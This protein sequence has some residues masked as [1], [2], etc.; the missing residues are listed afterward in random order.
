MVG[1]KAQYFWQVAGFV[2]LIITLTGP[3]D[4]ANVFEHGLARGYETA[5]G[6]TV[7]ALVGLLLWPV[8]NQQALV[9]T[10]RQF[11]AALEQAFGLCRDLML[12][13]TDETE[14]LGTRG[15]LVQLLSKL[16]AA[17]SA[18][19][20][21]SP[22]VREARELWFHLERESKQL[23]GD[24]DRWFL[25]C[26]DLRDVDIRGVVPRLEQFLVG[27]L[28]ESNA[29]KDAAADALQIDA[30]RL[31]SLSNFDRAA[32]TT[33]VRRIETASTRL[34]SLQDLNRALTGDEAARS[35]LQPMHA[36]QRALLIPV[37]DPDRL[38]AAMFVLASV[39]LGFLL[40]I[41]YDPPG[42]STL[43]MMAPTIGFAAAL[44]P[45]LMVARGVLM[46]FV[47]YLPVAAA[48]YLLVMPQ[49]SGYAQ[50]AVLIFAY[51]F[52]V[53]YSITNPLANIAAIMGFVTLM[54]IS[55]E[56]TYS[57]VGVTSNYL[58]MLISVLIVVVCSYLL[59]SPRPE[60]MVVRLV[61]RYLRSAAF[62]MSRVATPDGVGGT[63]L[64]RYR[65]RFHAQQLEILPAKVAAWGEQIDH[66]AF[67]T[68]S[69]DDV[70]RLVTSLQGFTYRLL[71][72]VEA[73]SD[74]LAAGLS[75]VFS[76]AATAW[77]EDGAQLLEDLSMRLTAS[78]ISNLGERVQAGLAALESGLREH[79]ARRDDSAEMETVYHLLGACRGVSTGLAGYA[80]AAD[81]IDWACWQEER[82]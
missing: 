68:N 71:S 3:S 40:W 38:R 57:F 11:A 28:L 47:L 74:A 7:W 1:S 25:G 45:Q 63:A 34:R 31:A 19:G 60:K 75:D 69:K 42:H 23:M 78:S 79:M 56:Q 50:L 39:W 76:G 61:R 15:Q 72:L 51:V 59:M 16:H 64:G 54:S 10:A 12:G 21:E 27:L 4:P 8:T 67:S 35:R 5:L 58:Y 2:C 73:R 81:A 44:T 62:V 52:W 29:A 66:A 6:C 55:N 13:R 26:R 82:F 77:R 36:P 46:P 20:A 70:D 33:V 32:V 22:D 49:L 37:P 9:D 17:L 41:F 48:L 53:Q 80:D 43:Y 18:A 65:A 14:Y 30:S 24:L